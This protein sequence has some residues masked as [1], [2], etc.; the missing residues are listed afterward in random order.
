MN[1]IFLLLVIVLL[2]GGCKKKLTQFYVE[3]NSETIIQSTFGQ[4]LP[5]NVQTPEITTNSESEFESNDTKKDYI[6][7]IKLSDLKLTI[8]SPDGEDFSFL[9]TINVFISNSQLGEK[10]IAFKESISNE[11]GSELI[12]DVVDANLAEYIKGSS[13]K[14]RIE[15]TTD[16]TIGQDITI[17]VYTRYFVDAKL[18]K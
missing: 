14:I 1:R 18:K 11:I 5:F 7:S 17:N 9:N 13:Y 6:N 10:K 3:D 4:I 12:C 8:L 16:E 2:F 15:A